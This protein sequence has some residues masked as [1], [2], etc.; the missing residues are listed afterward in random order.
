MNWA[1]YSA[2]RQYLT[3]E[4]VGSELRAAKRAENADANAARKA[5]QESRR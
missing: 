5:L 2:A 4:F 3:E 1:E